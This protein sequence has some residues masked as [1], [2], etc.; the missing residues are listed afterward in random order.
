ML[1]TLAVVARAAEGLQRRSGHAI[2]AHVSHQVMRPSSSVSPLREALQHA[3]Q[4]R[5][6]R[7]VLRASSSGRPPEQVSSDVCPSE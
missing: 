7:Q 1:S 3:G 2:L 5:T 6:M 4:R